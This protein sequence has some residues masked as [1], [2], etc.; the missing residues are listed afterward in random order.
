MEENIE[1][2][3]INFRNQESE[4]RF[5]IRL[6]KSDSIIGSIGLKITEPEVPY[7]EIGYWLKTDQTGQGYIIE[8]DELIEEYA[9]NNLSQ[10]ARDTYGK[11]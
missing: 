10:K 1:K 3:S 2:A 5:Y 8:A 9:F 6:K 7:Y 4:L 11:I